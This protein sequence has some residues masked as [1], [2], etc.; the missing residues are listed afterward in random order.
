MAG[1]SGTQYREIMP[2]VGAPQVAGPGGPVRQDV[3]AAGA[4]WQ[5]IAQLAGTGV[6]YVDALQNAADLNTVAQKRSEWGQRKSQAYADHVN[7]VSGVSPKEDMDSWGETSKRIDA[8]ILANTSPNV[9]RALGTY[10]SA[11]QN[12]FD[13]KVREGVYKAVEKRSGLTMDSSL[14]EKV[15]LGMQTNNPI[16]REQ[17]LLEQYKLVDAQV[18]AGLLSPIDAEVRKVKDRQQY[19]GDVFRGDL[20]KPD[21]KKAYEEWQTDA[22]VDSQGNTWKRLVGKDGISALERMSQTIFET[23]TREAARLAEKRE[24]DGIRDAN[25]RLQAETA[26]LARTGTPEQWEKNRQLVLASPYATP[27][28]IRAVESRPDPLDATPETKA[29]KQSIDRAYDS[30]TKKYDPQAAAKQAEDHQELN[31]RV[32]A[33]EKPI[34]AAAEIRK[35]RSMRESAPSGF[36]GEANTQ[37]LSAF[38]A[39]TLNRVVSGGLKREQAD[40]I[41]ARARSWV[42]GM[43]QFGLKK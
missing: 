25:T 39:A 5:G 8:D 38:E 36:Q 26:R 41:I 19:Y 6:K 22:P 42:A 21:W 30:M 24:T 14:A 10:F 17:Y 18:G 37:N 9:S 4:A 11:H 20:L 1:D 33:G 35:I 2:G 3:Q 29:A 23:R 15:A 12:T 31:R 27:E 32:Q 16:E 28:T 13:G 43:Q 40:K 7:S 34:E